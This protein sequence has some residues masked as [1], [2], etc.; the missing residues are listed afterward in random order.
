MLDGEARQHFQ[1]LRHFLN[2]GCRFL[3]QLMKMGFNLIGMGQENLSLRTIVDQRA[4]VVEIA[5]IRIQA[6]FPQMS[7]HRFHIKV[8]DALDLFVFA[9]S[10]TTFERLE[11]AADTFLN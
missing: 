9:M 3:A 10:I 5:Q 11:M 2:I 4:V 7:A 6:A 8:D 1:L